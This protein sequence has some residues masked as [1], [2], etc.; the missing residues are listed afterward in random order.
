[1]DR[2]QILRGILP[3]ATGPE[4]RDHV[5]H[6]LS[7]ERA[8]LSVVIAL[9]VVATAAG[10]VGPFLLGTVINDTAPGH[11]GPQVTL[12]ALVFLG[13]LTL[14]AVV[15]GFN[16]RL[17]AVLGERVLAR[18]REGFVADVLAVPLGVVERAGTGDLQARASSDVEQLS[19][20]VRMA[21]PEILVATITAA[22]TVGAL[23]WTAP[24]LAIA[25]VPAVPVLVAGTRWY[26]KRAPSLYRLEQAAFARVNSTIQESVSAG[27]TVEAFGLGERRVARTEEDIRQWIGIERATLRLR[28][29]FF[30]V[31]EAAYVIPLVLTVLLGGLLHLSGMLSVGAVTAA[32]LYAQQLVAPVDV[33]LSWLDELQLGSASLARLLGVRHVERGETTTDEPVGAT[34]V[35]EGVRFSYRSEREALRGVDLVLEPGDRLAVVGPSGAGKSTLALLLAGV[36]APTAG[37]VRIGGVDAHKIP[38]SRLRREIA[39]VTQEHHIFNGTVRQNLALVAPDASDDELLAALD[40]VDAGDFVRAMPAGLDT[41][42]GSGA[43]SL[44]PAHAQQLALARLV[45]AD[46]HT[47]ILDE[48]TSLLDPR[49]ARHLERSLARLL[50]GR[51]V[52]AIA[53]R[54]QTA[55]DADLVAVVEQGRITEYGAHA[56]LLAQG[57]AYASLWHSWQ[58]D[59]A[60]V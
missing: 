5:R 23:V 1:V 2:E 38:P 43:A 34:V 45:L 20:S 57:G 37:R 13:A 39:L 44:S 31:T 58:G 11:A 52:V 15:T 4:T 16:S 12:I 36:H 59:E 33:V 48:A 32:A 26:L 46:P 8:P 56:D 47:L 49:A 10:L 28:T 53:H 25:L 24:I 6:L 40:T 18:L 29:V 19:F 60:P 55:S 51:T 50:E 7:R 21:A 42:L 14:Q 30:P 22:L 41:R 54:L 3:V 27:R 17:T 35:A 9:Q